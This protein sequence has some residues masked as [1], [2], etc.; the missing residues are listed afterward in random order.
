[1]KIIFDSE[2]QKEEFIRGLASHTC[3]NELGL[4]KR[5]ICGEGEVNAS[6]IERCIKCFEQ[7]GLEMVVGDIDIFYICDRKACEICNKE[8]NHT[9]DIEHAVNRLSLHGRLFSYLDRGDCKGLFEMEVK[10]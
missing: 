7:S 6:T 5:L 2:E 4:S 10:V 9:S 1:M 3:P 8:C